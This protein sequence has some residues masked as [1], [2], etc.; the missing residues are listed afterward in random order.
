MIHSTKKKQ[1]IKQQQKIT[2]TNY[3]ERR[4]VWTSC[5]KVSNFLCSFLP[6][7]SPPTVICPDHNWPENI[8]D[9]SQF[10]PEY[11]LELSQTFSCSFSPFIF[12]F[13]PYWKVF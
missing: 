3:N 6:N 7:N 4:P 9:F 11:V 12:C 2:N 5:K 13:L 10:R 1:T 8:F